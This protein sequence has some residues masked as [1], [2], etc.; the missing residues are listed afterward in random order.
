M[1]LRVLL[2]L[3]FVFSGTAVFA[4]RIVWA[5]DGSSSSS[6]ATDWAGS[7]RYTYYVAGTTQADITSFINKWSTA[8][9]ADG[10]S[11]QGGKNSNG[12]DPWT[13]VLDDSFAEATSSGT[14][15]TGYLVV[16]LEKDGNAVYSWT[17][18]WILTGD[19][20]SADLDKIA[21]FNDEGYR[22]DSYAGGNGGSWAK[23]GDTPVPEPGMLALLAL[24]VAG[25][26]L[27]RKVA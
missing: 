4:S 2:M 3:L 24:G 11:V 9:V 1:K 10:S 20:E 25:L 6:L 23:V 17:D 14:K 12:S 21:Y 8:Y 22:T 26:A 16:L 18:S 7:N 27:R 19:Q 15:G 5:I 13:G